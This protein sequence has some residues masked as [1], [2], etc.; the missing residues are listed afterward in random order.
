MFLNAENDGF[1]LDSNHDTPIDEDDLPDLIKAFQERDV[2]WVE[3]CD[4]NPD[5]NWKMNWWFAEANAIRAT[6]FNLSAN[7][8]RPLNRS[9][10]EH[11]DPM[12]ILEELRGIETQILSEIDDLVE[13]LRGVEE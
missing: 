7:Q 8:Y 11:R 6:D 1:K 9:K 12:E 4:R 13:V 3:W 2:K 5:E 10:I